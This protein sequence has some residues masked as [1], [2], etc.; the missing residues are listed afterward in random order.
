[1]NE[2]ILTPQEVADILKLKKNT[3]Y[4]MIKRGDIKASKMGKQFRILRKDVDAYLAAQ[5]NTKENVSV[6][7]EA[8]YV[9]TA[10]ILSN[11]SGTFIICGQDILLD[12]ICNYL[13]E[14]TYYG[15]QALRSYKGSYNALYSMYQGQAQ[16]ATAHM[17]D[18]ETDTYNLP[19]VS[20]LFPGLDIAVFH[21]ACRKQGFYVP[22][23]NPLKIKSFEDFKRPELRF[24]NR[25]LGSGT[26][27]LLDCKIQKLKISPQLIQGYDNVVSSHLEAATRVAKGDADFAL[28]NERT[29]LQLSS[30]D[31][32][33]LQTESYEMFIRTSDMSHPLFSKI[34]QLIQ[35]KEFQQ[36]VSLMGGYDLTDMGKRL[37]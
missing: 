28:G 34:I 35:S 23:G 27:I 29:S 21:L 19:Y 18:P 37:M 30:I 11:Q 7:S 14:N 36:E 4:E 24:V 16:I 8:S 6:I 17:W 32:V 12:K 9:Q 15:I 26:R 25:E 20:K 10:P 33:P 22:A 5:S 1:M 31:F 3:V 2:T 13:N